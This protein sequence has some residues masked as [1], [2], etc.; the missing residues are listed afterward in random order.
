MAFHDL[1]LC[2]CWAPDKKHCIISPSVRPY[3]FF[4]LNLTITLRSLFKF[5][6]VKGNMYL[7][8]FIVFY[9]H[10]ILYLIIG[11]TLELLDRLWFP[12]GQRYSFLYFLILIERWPVY[13]RCW[14]H[15]C[16]SKVLECLQPQKNI[17]CE[18]Y[19]KMDMQEIIREIVFIQGF[20][21]GLQPYLLLFIS[22]YLMPQKCHMLVVPCTHHLFSHVCASFSCCLCLKH[23][24]LS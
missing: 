16:S 21:L 8:W 13:S 17:F 20:S 10:L 23:P 11:N 19:R 18:L 6:K 1:F 24:S 2:T 14:A 22:L 4:N 3:S 7:S 12:Q 5:P 9:S 15:L